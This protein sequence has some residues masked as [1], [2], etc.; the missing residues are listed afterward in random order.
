MGIENAVSHV[1]HIYEHT[2]AELKGKPVLIGETGW[3]SYGRQRQEAVPTLVNQA[4]FIREFSLRAEQEKIPYNVI[5]A[6]DQP[7]K[8][9]SEG[10]VGGYWG[11]YSADDTAKFPFR[12]P[13]AEAASWRDAAGVAMLAV[14]GIF[15]VIHQ[16]RNELGAGLLVTLALISISGGAAWMGFCRDLVMSNRNWLEWLFTEVYAGLLLVAIFAIG[17]PLALWLA[18]RQSPQNP[19]PVADVLVAWRDRAEA[20]ERLAGLLGVLRFLFLFSAAMICLLLAVDVHPHD[21]PLALFS[22]PAVGLALLSWINGGCEAG[23]EE[24]LLAGLTGFGGLWI[25]VNEH[26]ITVQD[27]PWQIADGLNQ[28][29]LWWTLLCLLLAWSVLGPTGVKLAAGQGQRP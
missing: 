16:R 14:F 24:K 7:W 28:H 17:S 22:A 23:V 20:F 5:E 6:F 9:N 15:V 26:L 19:A 1:S 8:R 21:F 13:V 10:A 25:V 29:A 3:P 4:R 2:K 18:G 27:K 11:I 12:G